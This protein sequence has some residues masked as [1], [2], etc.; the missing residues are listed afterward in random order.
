ME[1]SSTKE[2]NEITEID[3]NNITNSM[4]RFI[5]NPYESYE[6]SRGGCTPTT[7]YHI[8]N[9]PYWQIQ[10]LDPITYQVIFYLSG[11]ALFKSV[12]REHKFNINGVVNTQPIDIFGI[13][14]H[15]EFMYDAVG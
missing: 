2:I 13:V 1:S 9:S 12:Y 4:V 8:E 15:L 10:V 5:Y 3:I 11:T 6:E 14:T 7:H